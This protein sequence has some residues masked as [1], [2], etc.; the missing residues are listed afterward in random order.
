MVKRIIVI[1]CAILLAVIS[2]YFI[3]GWYNIIPWS[4]AAIILGYLNLD[5]KGA[6]INGALFGYF[7]FFVYILLGYGGKTDAISI[8]RILLFAVLFSLIGAAAGI[9]GSL[10]GNY[11]SR[12]IKS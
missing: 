6:L 3:A 5:R 2:N 9:I 12:K 10:I 7:L 1:A 11:I 8:L 4:I